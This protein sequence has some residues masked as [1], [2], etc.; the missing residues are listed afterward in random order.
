MSVAWRDVQLICNGLPGAQESTSYG[1]PA[2]KVGKALFVRWHQDGD[3]L[4]LKTT[5][6]RRDQLL[7]RRPD[8]YLLTDHYL[9]YPYILARTDALTAELLAQALHD[10]WQ[11]VL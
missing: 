4:V 3:K 6:E 2:F 8:I 1:T 5:L 10:A 11:S 9:N 7:E